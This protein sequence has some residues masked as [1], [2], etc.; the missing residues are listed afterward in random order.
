MNTT[1][2]RLPR[3]LPGR[4]EPEAGLPERAGGRREGQAA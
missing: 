1:W 3:Q 4:R 2:R